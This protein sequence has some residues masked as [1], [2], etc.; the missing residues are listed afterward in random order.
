TASQVVEDLPARQDREAVRLT[1]A[2]SPHMW[3]Q[4]S[5]ELPVAADPAVLASCEREVVAGIVVVD[6]DVRREAGTR[7]A[8]FD[9]VVREQGILREPAVCR[10]LERIDVVDAFA[11]VAALAVQVLVDVGY[12]CRV[13]IDARMPGIDRREA[14]L[15]CA[16]Q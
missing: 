9:Q 7:V 15:V 13:R 6:R 2:R 12:G 4:P 14:R 1:A 16:R 8:A 10:G 5:D 3:C 11:G